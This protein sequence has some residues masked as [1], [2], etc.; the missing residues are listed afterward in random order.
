MCYP[1]AEYRGVPEIDWNDERH[2]TVYYNGRIWEVKEDEARDWLIFVRERPEA[3]QRITSGG[4]SEAIRW[5][6]GRPRC[7]APRYWTRIDNGGNP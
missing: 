6:V 2:A 4:C 1:S 7:W 5:I 3:V